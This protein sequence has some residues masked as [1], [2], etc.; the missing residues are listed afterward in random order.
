MGRWS[1]RLPAGVMAAGL[2]AL[3]GCGGPAAGADKAAGPAPTRLPAAAAGGACQLLD[4]DVVATLLG[5]TFDVAAASQTGAT[6]T[7]VLERTQENLPDLALS[8]TAT[9]ADAGIFRSTVAPA[10]AASV[11]GLGKAGY[12]AAVG[13]G[14]GAG[15]GIEVG[16][17]SGNQ[18]IMTLRLR[19]PP[20]T[21]TTEANALVPKLV[22]LA[23]QIDMTTV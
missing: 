11:P 1:S 18:R 15:P 9:E 20:G 6:F 10:G 21:P 8:V 23:K 16:W 19:T 2:I 7:C 5:P 4:Y 22:A 13:A 14:S 3:G 12:R 17:L